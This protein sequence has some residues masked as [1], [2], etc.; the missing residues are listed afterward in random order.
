VLFTWVISRASRQSQTAGALIA[1]LFLGVFLY[2]QQGNGV[3]SALR[4]QLHSSALAHEENEISSV[5]DHPM[6]S[7][8]L[9]SDLPLVVSSNLWFLEVDHLAPASLLSRMYY[10]TDRKLSLQYTGTDLYANG[11]PLLQKWF[12]IRAQVQD[13]EQFMA[14]HQ[15]FLL[16]APSSYGLEWMVRKL[17]A[18]GAAMQL[19]ALD[20]DRVLLEVV[21]QR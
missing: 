9:K 17:T 1:L 6:L 14:A 15:R 3:I 21:P 7:L 8:A 2:R 19:L 5:P 4:Q 13:Y 20:S 10:L 16:Y 11:F 12:P 18:D